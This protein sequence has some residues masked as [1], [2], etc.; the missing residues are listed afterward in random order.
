MPN[1]E[2][3]GQIETELVALEERIA[4]AAL[5]DFAGNGVDQIVTKVFEE[6]ARLNEPLSVDWLWR[7]FEPGASP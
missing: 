1:D 6:A 2:R 3:S 5:A 4:F 7:Y